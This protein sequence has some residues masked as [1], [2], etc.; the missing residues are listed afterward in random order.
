MIG[1]LLKEQTKALHDLVE[2]K[3]LSH[4]IMDK[5]FTVMEYHQVLKHNY[6]FLH[7]FEDAV[8]SSLSDDTSQK[9]RLEDR[10]KLPFIKKDLAELGLT[11]SE[12][13]PLLKIEIKTEAE[14]LGMLYVMEG[15]TLGGNI[16]AKNLAKNPAF[17]DIE[18][19]YFGCYGE[20]TGSLWKNFREV[21]ESKSTEVNSGDFLKGAKKAY[22]FLLDL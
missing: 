16:I 17:S 7:H 19:H 3:L 6:T 1:L 15:S 4:K 22:Q 21:L 8:F 12:K 18:F 2:E 10:K 11:D 5:S 13:Q 14:A 9:I 20:K